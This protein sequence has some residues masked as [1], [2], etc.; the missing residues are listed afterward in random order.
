[1]SL[2]TA[3]TSF[4]C[5]CVM[6][7]KSMAVF[8]KNFRRGSLGAW[9]VW[10]WNLSHFKLAKFDATIFV[11]VL[12]AAIGSLWCD[13]VEWRVPKVASNYDFALFW[14]NELKPCQLLDILSLSRIVFHVCRGEFGFMENTTREDM[15]GKPRARDRKGKLWM[16]LLK[17]KEGRQIWDKMKYPKFHKLYSIFWLAVVS[18]FEYKQNDAPSV[19]REDVRSSFVFLPLKNRTFEY[20]CFWK[21]SESFGS[22][23]PCLR[24]GVIVRRSKAFLSSIWSGLEACNES[25]G[26]IWKKGAQ[27]RL[28]ADLSRVKGLLASEWRAQQKG[29]EPY[30]GRRT[31]RVFLCCVHLLLQFWKSVLEIC[32]EWGSEQMK[33]FLLWAL[34]WIIKR[35]SQWSRKDWWMDDAVEKEVVQNSKEGTV[36]GLKG[37]RRTG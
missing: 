7:M 20:I 13:L 29:Y 31:I 22:V 17:W 9:N 32:E 36:G 4:C 23:T 34:P 21:V 28:H 8:L 25:L 35:T 15:E 26:L 33:L 27:T 1:M 6:D 12:W 10:F 37:R 30:V 5:A 16:G 14:Q 18:S 3:L 19:F 2:F 11:S 24:K